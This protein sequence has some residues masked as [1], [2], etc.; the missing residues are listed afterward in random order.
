MAERR[1]GK[2]SHL[3]P[4]WLRRVAEIGVLPSDSEELRLRKTVLVLSTALMGCLA[5]V[6]VGTF[7]ALG[8]WV[9]AAIPLAYQVAS[10]LGL[11]ALARTYRY[12][13]FRHSQLWL[14]LVLPFAL[15]WSLGG[16]RNSSTVCLW[17][18]TSPL[19]ALLFLGTR[20]A[21]PW[22]VAFAGL[23]AASGAIDPALAAGAPHIPDG[24]V[25][26]FFV[27]NVVGV[28][29]VAYVLLR[30][31]EQA[32]DREHA[33][34]ERLLRNVLPAS[35]A[36]RL[37]RDDRVIADAHEDVTVLFADI[38]DFTPL[39]ERLPPDE[40][41][42]VL[43]RVFA[44][45]DQLAA[46]HR[47]EKIKTIGDA[48]MVAAGIPQPHEQPTEAIADM[49]LAM[50]PALARVA[51]DTGLPLEVRIGI[52]TGPV[53][54]GV[55]GRAKFIYDLWGDT[56]NTASRMQSLAPRGAIQ[57]TPRTFDRLRAGYDLEPRGF[58]EIKGKGPLETHLL[59]GA[60]DRPADPGVPSKR[61]PAAKVGARPAARA[62]TRSTAPAAP[63]ARSAAAP[64][65]ARGCDAKVRWSA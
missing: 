65:A 58:I 21:A 50:R 10:I 61:A 56:V 48:Y 53:I 54:A 55:I 26:T 41:V 63:N 6:W 51:A 57:V 14:T 33:R 1:A 37:K 19:G 4:A 25:I 31:F 52:D 39:S 45:W 40:L 15:Q 5:F 3:P 30:H 24:V 46:R 16:F 2:Q 11:I 36:V 42:A 23:V 49:A 13:W 47:L 38:A 60:S 64:C 28:T 9:S 43:D 17:A 7:A 29:T 44:A 32:R 34:S 59:I 8:L 35:V 18:F 22:L 62:G 27:L 12:K 20:Q